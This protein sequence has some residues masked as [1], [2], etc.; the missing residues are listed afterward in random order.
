MQKLCGLIFVSALP[1][2]GGAQAFDNHHVN[3]AAVDYFAGPTKADEGKPTGGPKVRQFTRT[4]GAEIRE[5]TVVKCDPG[6]YV[7][8]LVF[9][10]EWC[11]P[12]R[13]D[14]GA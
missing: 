8:R 3:G 7:V 5:R 2:A 10:V 1:C 14:D 4:K 13:G 9:G 11:A 6:W 12:A